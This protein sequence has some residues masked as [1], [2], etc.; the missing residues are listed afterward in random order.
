[1]HLLQSSFPECELCG[2]LYLDC[3]RV[4]HHTNAYTSSQVEGTEGLRKLFYSAQLPVSHQ[5][6]MLVNNRLFKFYWSD[7]DLFT[8]S[9]LVL[10][11]ARRQISFAVFHSLLHSHH[12]H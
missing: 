7:S 5:P 4:Y 3:S 1:M 12:G 2:G 6:V 9:T 10:L 11:Q 8:E